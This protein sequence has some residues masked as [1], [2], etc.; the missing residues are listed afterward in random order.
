M[1][2]AANKDKERRRYDRY[3]TEVKIYFQ[4]NY[5]IQTKVKYQII[6]K[7]KEETGSQK[8]S[9]LSK[10]VSAQGICFTSDRRLTKGDLLHLEIYLPK[11]KEPIHMEG[12][13]R[14]SVPATEKT[15]QSE[16]FDTGVQLITVNGQSVDQT[17]YFDKSHQIIWSIVLESTLGN[18]RLL[19]RNRNKSSE[20][21]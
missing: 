4:V 9:A 12:E 7:A 15:H 10:N 2:A 18:F 20:S 17:I 21:H 1:C 6:D 11:G 8:Y 14:W 3:D 13:V 19:T 16:K 5:D